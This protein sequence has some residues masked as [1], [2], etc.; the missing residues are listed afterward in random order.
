MTQPTPPG[1]YPDPASPASHRFWDG[2]SW[3]QQT[4]DMPAPD[5]AALVAEP[6]EPLPEASPDGPGTR[7]D[8]HPPAS[9]RPRRGALIV[10]GA[11]AAIGIVAVMV[12]QSNKPSVFE[13]AVAD[14]ELEGDSGARIADDGRSLI[15][16]NQGE[17]L[18]AGLDIFGLLCIID[19][20]ETPESVS[21]QMMQTTSLQGRQSA[22]WGG[23]EASWTYHPDNGLDIIVSRS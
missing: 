6:S 23:L 4:R 16:D 12:V 3:T 1:W 8:T 19:A 15:I 14:C 13:S 20:L 2:N 11:M 22:S 10:I 7:G 18:T 9:G 5:P 21:E 17:D